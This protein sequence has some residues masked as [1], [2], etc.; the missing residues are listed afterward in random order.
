M[1]KKN[2]IRAIVAFAVALAFI[3]PG[4]AMFANIDDLENN[5]EEIRT[6]VI[7]RDVVWEY[8]NG[9]FWPMDADRLENGNTLIADYGN[10]RVIEI[11]SNGS[12]VWEYST[13]L[14]HPKDADRLDNNN[15]LITDRNNHRIIEVT[16]DKNIIWEYGIFPDLYYPEDADRLENNN[17]L[18]SDSYN[19]R[20]IE[21]TS[22]GDIVWEYST[23]LDRPTDADRL[24]NNNTLITDKGHKRIIEITSDGSIIWEYSTDISGAPWDAY[25]READ[26]LENNNTLIADTGNNRIIEVTPDGNIV[27]EYNTGL[28]WPCD[29]DRLENGNTLIT[30]CDNNRI[31]EVDTSSEYTLTVNIEGSGTVA[32]DPDQ[33]TYLEGTVVTLTA[34][35]NPGWNFSHWTGNLTGSDNPT[36]ITM[37]SDKIVTAYFFTDSGVSP[38]E[39]EWNRTFGGTK[40]D[41]GRS[42]QQT[43][44]G[45]YIIIGHTNSFGTNDDDYDFYLVKTDAYGNETWNRTFGGTDIDWGYSVQ[46]TTD[47]GYILTGVTKSYGPGGHDCWLIKTDANGNMIWDKTFGT[48][49]ADYGYSVQQTTDG[50]YIIAGRTN[51]FSDEFIDYD[52]WLIKT[53]AYGNMIWNKTYGFSG[54]NIEEAYSV[55]QTTD[56]GYILVGTTCDFRILDFNLYVVKT[57]AD[58]KKIYDR[59]LGEINSK[60]W[61]FSVQQT[62]DG[63]YILTGSKGV[64]LPLHAYDIWLIKMDEYLR[65]EWDKTFGG[66]D[67]DWGYSVQQTTD[68][69]YIIA[70]STESYGAGGIDC[71]L[72]KTDANGNMIWDKTIGGSNDEWGYSVQQTIDSG[73]IIAG[74]TDSYGAGRLDFWLIKVEEEGDNTPPETPERPEGPTE[75]MIGVEYT[76]STSTTD[77]EEDKVSYLWDWGDETP[78]EWTDFYDSGVTVHA[79]H[80]WNEINEYNITV[81]AK[82][83]HNVESNWSD[84]K[85]IHI[86]GPVLEIG[87]ITGGL[88]KVNAVIKNIGSADAT[89]VDWSIKLDGGLIILGKETIGTIASIPAGNEALIKSDLIFGIGRTT[90]TVA[91]ECAEGSSANETANAFVF[92]FFIKIP[93]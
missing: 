36:N 85:K 6:T 72:I 81:K 9:L 16:P 24:E 5:I 59:T 76:F 38:P 44:D 45:G 37:D 47:G 40:H 57:D 2:K 82:D 10:N 1:Y 8:S 39:E 11:A 32:K 42:V 22:D 50:G 31:I 87:N 93:Y 35:A 27:W 49:F 74:S 80:I 51:S 3:M 61:G 79:N 30:D 62:T 4:A 41:H 60:E 55:Q 56:G 78:T 73:Y 58:G 15:T 67:K 75:G 77:P 65:I 25:P 71:W 52:F 14:D 88:F 89:D 34:N 63:G 28:D 21:I 17:T 19:N 54:K 12:I 29:A 53:N 70:G 83:V 84:S 91:A 26:R 64:I 86:I 20:I 7:T 48:R 66:I 68:E 69:G 92:L 43:T 46:Q 90:I 18:I 33:A 23:S 13:G